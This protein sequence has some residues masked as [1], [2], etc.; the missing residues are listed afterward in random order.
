MQEKKAVSRLRMLLLAILLS[1]PTVLLILPAGRR[2]SFYMLLLCALACMAFRIKPDGQ[3]FRA[4]LKKY[5]SINLAM[6]AMLIA[7]IVQQLALWSF[8]FKPIEKAL[9]FAVFPL[10][11]WTLLLLSASNLRILQ[12]ALIIGAGL[13]SIALHVAMQGGDVRANGVVFNPLIP[14]S[15]LTLL[16]GF[17]TLLS[18]GWNERSEKFVIALKVLIFCACLY[19]SYISGT[20]GGWIAIPFLFIVAISMVGT[21]RLRHKVLISLAAMTVIAAMTAFMPYTKSRAELAYSEMVGF[22]HSTPN[23]SS[24]SIGVRFQLWAVSWNIFRHHPVLGIGTAEFEQ[25]VANLAA[26]GL[27]TPEAGRQLHAHNDFMQ[28]LATHGAFG[29]IALLALYLVPAVWFLK[30]ARV[31]DKKQR[32]TAGM[33]LAV[34]VG[35][36]IYGMTDTLFY[37][38]VCSQFYTIIVATLFAL[39]VKQHEELTRTE[40]AQ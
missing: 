38:S 34:S 19:A 1:F 39:L 28:A 15:D 36:F 27:I 10:L 3:E 13:S 22:Q 8:A 35:F 7:V 31:P 21:I 29:A 16:M 9:E 12:W 2:L 14:F 37:W 20:R 33:G 11:L 24:T 40:F 6:A 32:V 5:R 18:V 17:M 26:Q 23:S 30:L 4:V 25:E